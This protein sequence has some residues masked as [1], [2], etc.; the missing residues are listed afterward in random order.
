MGTDF[1]REF[2]DEVYEDEFYDEHFDEEEL[3]DDEELK[4][5]SKD[6]DDEPAGPEEED[7]ADAVE[8]EEVEWDEDKE[9]KVDVSYACE[10]CDYRWEDIIV[11]KKDR[12]EDEEEIDV[13]CPM[14]G[15]VNITQI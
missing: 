3:I 5:D 7:A 2:D 15:S 9:L 11:K 6:L 14:C 4:D 10:D 8:S 13:V 12:L 1:E